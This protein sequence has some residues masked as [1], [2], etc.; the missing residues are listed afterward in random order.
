VIVLDRGFQF[1]FFKLHNH[2]ETLII[3]LIVLRLI[4]KVGVCY[5]QSATIICVAA[6]G[7]LPKSFFDKARLSVITRSG[8]GNWESGSCGLVG[9]CQQSTTILGMSC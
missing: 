7:K 5:F 4:L 2:F 9:G 6:I 3:R 1:N 8:D